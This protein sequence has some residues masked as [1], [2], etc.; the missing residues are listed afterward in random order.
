[1]KNDEKTV[2]KEIA[3]FTKPV[4]DLKQKAKSLSWDSIE[5]V[6]LPNSQ[7]VEVIDRCLNH[8]FSNGDLIEWAN[9]VESRET[10]EM[11]EECKEAIFRLANPALEGEL[12]PEQLDDIKQSLT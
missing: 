11:S 2:L 12:T 3:S 7:V 4:S 10:Y 5:S 6:P 1:M 8:E 9:L